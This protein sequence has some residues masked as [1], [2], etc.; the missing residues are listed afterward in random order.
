MEWDMPRGK[1]FWGT[2]VANVCLVIAFTGG[3]MSPEDFFEVFKW[4][5]IGF[6]GAQSLV[7]M[8]GKK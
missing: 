1:K 5:N 3:N 8:A 7:D 4:L 6:L 2:I